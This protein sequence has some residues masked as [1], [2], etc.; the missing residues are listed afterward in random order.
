MTERVAT[1]NSGY[2][3]KDP[4]PDGGYAGTLVKVEACIVPEQNYSGKIKAA[5]PGFWLTYGIKDEDA[6]DGEFRFLRKRFRESFYDAKGKESGLVSA[7]KAMQI[8]P[9]QNGESY[10]DDDWLGAACMLSI[11]SYEYEGNTFNGIK[12]FGPLPGV[13]KKTMVVEAAQAREAFVTYDAERQARI[14]QREMAGAGS[15]SF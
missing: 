13:L 3:A 10:D 9:P 1:V 4:L 11:D 8:I 7:L 12:S 15:P 5:G 14:E 2:V 6:N